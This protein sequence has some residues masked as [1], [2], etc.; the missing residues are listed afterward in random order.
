[1]SSYPDLK[2]CQKKGRIVFAVQTTFSFALIGLIIYLIGI[3]RSIEPMVYSHN[4]VPVE[5][6]SF[7]SLMDKLKVEL[8]LVHFEI[9]DLD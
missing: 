9:P 4:L 5:S 3:A 6:A 2:K 8:G 1:M 7:L